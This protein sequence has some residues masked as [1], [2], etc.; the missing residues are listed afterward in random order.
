MS[1]IKQISVYNGS[2]WDS[3]DIGADAANITL[4]S[5]LVGSTNLQTALGNILP[6]DNNLT[7]SRVVI[8]GNDKK[9][10]TS[11][12]TGTKLGYLSDVSSNIQTQ[13]NNLSNNKYDKTGGNITGTVILKGASVWTSDGQVDITKTQ[14]SART[15]NGLAL[16]DKNGVLMGSVFPTV[17][18]NNVL[19]TRI[20]AIRNIN[21]TTYSN[22]LYLQIAEDGTKTVAFSS[23]DVPVWRDALGINNT[24]SV[25]N[26]SSKNVAT[27]TDY[28]MGNTGSL[29]AGTYIIRYRVSF[30]GNMTGR[31]CIYLATATNSNTPA[32][33]SRIQHAPAP[34]STTELAGTVC[35][36]ISSTTTYYLR[37]YHQA[38]ATLACTGQLQV[39]KIH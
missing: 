28:T 26:I 10:A 6:A 7:A 25:V 14:S 13:L 39:L 19:S 31:R 9:L 22:N 15:C 33:Y 27:A 23:G 29:S 30:E 35:V 18:A 24:V 32:V 8:T 37:A 1:V 4:G 36:T 12:I 38:G 2:S 16:S 3:N 20:G 34:N 17:N 5:K 21:G 11:S